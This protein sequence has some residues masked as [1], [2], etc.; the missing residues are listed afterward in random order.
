MQETTSQDATSIAITFVIPSYNVE[1]YLG[2]C[3]SSLLIEQDHTGVEILVVND[4][5]TDGT[6][7][8]AHD[9]E[10][11]FSDV[12]RVIDQPNKGHGGAV[13]TG[14]DN[15]RGTYIK[16]VDADD[17]LDQ[18][19][20]RVVLD[21][22]RKQSVSPAP[23]DLLITNYRY[24]KQGKRVKKTVRYRNVM[25]VGRPFTW[26]E[27]KR[28][29]PD[30]NLLMHSFTY[31]TAILREKTQLV[32]PEHTFYVDNLYAYVPLPH[33]RTMLY[34]DVDLYQ[35]FI[36]RDGQSVEEKTMISRID[37]LIRVVE[38]M[39]YATPQPEGVPAGLYRYM[40]HYLTINMGIDSVFMVLSKNPE[41]YEHKAQLWNTLRTQN[42]KAYDAVTHTLIGRLLTVPG[43]LG[44]GLIH[45]GYGIAHRFIGVN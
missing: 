14:I 5:S 16:V 18:E 22:V 24:D 6:L 27:V 1:Q 2:R 39:I 26:N 29:A 23:I 36:G 13:N 34:L 9:Y 33:V 11:Q 40:I 25:P 43:A 21:E 31:R 7:Q 38:A 15:A 30:Q 44:R 28:M 10:E 35:Y 32:L 12:I 8:L 20:L 41:H 42:P 3:L 4:G 37:Q 19:A 45:V 17:W